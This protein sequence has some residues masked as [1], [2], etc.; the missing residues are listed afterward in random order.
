[1]L[2]NGNAMVISVAWQVVLQTLPKCDEV[3]CIDLTPYHNAT[4]DGA[5]VVFIVIFSMS[6]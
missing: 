6:F 4:F 5:I 1:M 3:I 2:L